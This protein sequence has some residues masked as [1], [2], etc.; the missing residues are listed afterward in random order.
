MFWPPPYFRAELEAQ[1]GHSEYAIVVVGEAIFSVQVAP[2]PVEG[3][4]T[5][6]SLSARGKDRPS[7]DH[8]ESELNPLF[9]PAVSTCM[10][11]EL[12]PS[13]LF[14]PAICIPTIGMFP[15]SLR[16][17]PWP[18]VAAPCHLFGTACSH[19]RSVPSTK[20]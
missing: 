17:C 11:P 16:L 3:A 5:V 18:V 1:N 12:E 9:P 7:C 6:R 13:L 8:L 10:F 14:V 2:F 19:G 4:H 15:G 20:E